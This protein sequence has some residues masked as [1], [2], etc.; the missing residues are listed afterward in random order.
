MTEAQALTIYR[1]AQEALTNVQRHAGART[2]RLSLQQ[3]NGGVRVQIEDDGRG[4]DPVREVPGIGL[5]GMRERA[6][7]LQGTVD[8]ESQPQQGSRLTLTL[9]IPQET[10]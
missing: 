10:L 8:I 3:Q 5:R 9:P 1:M 7:Q 6:L 4:F 2:V